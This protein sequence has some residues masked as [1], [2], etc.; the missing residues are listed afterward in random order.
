M[1]MQV[2]T[3]HSRSKSGGETPR[4]G[5]AWRP[6]PFYATRALAF[7]TLVLIV[8]IAVFM[9]RHIYVR[10][11]NEAQRELLSFDGLLAEQ[12]ARAIQSVQLVQENVAE[13][14]HAAGLSEPGDLERLAGGHDV[15]VR[16]KQRIGGIPQLDAVSLIASDG[17]LVN[18]SRFWP[19][20]NIQIRDRD[21]F[22]LIS[23]PNAPG[24]AWGEPVQNRGTGTWTIYLAHRLTGPDGQFLGLVLGAMQTEYFETLYRKLN[25]P[26]GYSIGLWREDGL[27]LAHFPEST[28]VGHHYTQPFSFRGIKPGEQRI[29]ETSVTLQGDTRL[30]ASIRLTDQPI[31]VA[32]TRSTQTIFSDWRLDVSMIIAASTLGA[33]AVVVISWLLI[34][35]FRA[36]ETSAA[37]MHAREMAERSLHE[38]EARLLQGQ[39]MEAMGRLTAGV[40][41]DFNNL[42][43]V[44]RAN[45]ELLT[46]A[47]QDPKAARRLNTICQAADRGA[48]L[49]RQM[50]AFSRQQMLTPC[51]LDV[52]ERLRAVNELLVSSLGSRVRFTMRLSDDLWPAFADAAQLEQA[53]LNLVINARDAVSDGG[54]IEVETEN[55]SI[56]L[57]QASSHLLP[58]DYVRV[59]VSDTGEGMTAEVVSRAFD[60]FFTTK[61]QG[62]G[63][64]ARPE[65]GGGLRAAIEW[66]RG[67]GI[68]ARPGHPCTHPA[69]ARQGRAHRAGRIGDR[70]RRAIRGDDAN[71]AA[72]G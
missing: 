35:R 12:T 3:R 42:L 64:G 17:E 1:D 55:M 57:A 66:R 7:V 19:I 16:L 52:N 53:I 65:P 32:V 50:L 39:K 11:L 8:V 45:A 31:V 14:L 2:A 51:S 72:G 62:R 9:A 26:V 61:E 69:A 48:T 70:S 44:V 38:A 36:Y 37:A 29:A 59:T 10:E 63:T 58:G 54:L 15:F 18:F 23:Q 46:S 28:G 6:D 20:P 40:A 56:G 47:L 27:L 22:H 5:R 30:V 13:E 33:M 71:R 24:S 67:A 49:T 21:Y 43:T 34:R 4:S 68:H 41:H 25:L 60:P